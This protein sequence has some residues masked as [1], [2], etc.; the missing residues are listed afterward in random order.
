MNTTANNTVHFSEVKSISDNA[1][2]LQH[3]VLMAMDF[4]D[5]SP[6]E[7]RTELYDAMR[8][9]WG[10]LTADNEITSVRRILDNVEG[11]NGRTDWL[12]TFKDPA[13]VNVMAR[14]MLHQSGIII[15]WLE[16]FIDNYSKDF[17][18]VPFEDE[19][20]EDDGAG[21]CDE[22]NDKYTLVGV[23][24]NAFAV[25]GYVTKAMRECKLPKADIDEYCSKAQS[26]DYDNLLA[27]SIEYVER[28]N[29]AAR[30][31]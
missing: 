5:M 23:D 13:E 25:M 21:Y 10:F 1:T 9:N 26:G 3:V 15:K 14:L 20:P 11:D 24:G 17:N 27:V 4:G 29:K 6:E 18:W 28:C 19:G 8:N 22:D 7:V 12:I 2:S 30:C 16:D 31:A